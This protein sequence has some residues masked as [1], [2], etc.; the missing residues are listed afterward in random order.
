[1]ADSTQTTQIGVLF[2]QVRRPLS[3]SRSKLQ[4]FNLIIPAE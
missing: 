2:E 3:A 4:S 1:M